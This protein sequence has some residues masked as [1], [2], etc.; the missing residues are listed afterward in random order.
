MS[1]QYREE[2]VKVRKRIVKTASGPI[3]ERKFVGAH[4]LGRIALYD[5]NGDPASRET[6]ERLKRVLENHGFNVKSRSEKAKTGEELAELEKAW[7]KKHGRNGPGFVAP[8]QTTALAYTQSGMDVDRDFTR[9]FLDGDHPLAVFMHWN[10]QT[11]VVGAAH[12][13]LDLVSRGQSDYIPFDVLDKSVLFTQSSQE[14]TVLANRVSPKSWA[15]S[16]RELKRIREVVSDLSMK[17]MGIADE[18]EISLD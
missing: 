6:V 1:P 14:A 10:G 7:K 4:T 16:L 2:E 13:R 8:T 17:N 11:A 5:A 18:E 3:E 9:L 12:Y 15:E